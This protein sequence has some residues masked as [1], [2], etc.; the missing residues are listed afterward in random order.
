MAVPEELLKISVEEYLAFEE[1]S[2]VRH[3]Y[4]AGYVFA[5]ARA[6]DAHNVIAGNVF[7]R[8]RQHIRRS[9][10]RVYMVDMKVRVEAVDAFYYPDVMVTCEPF[11]AK[12]VFKSKPILLVEVL[13]PGTEVT[14]RREKLSAYFKL[15]SLMEYILI[16]QDKKRVEIYRRD[17]RG[18]IQMQV[19]EASEVRFESPPNGP[20]T[21]T[22][23]DIY[24]DVIFTQP[25]QPPEE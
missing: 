25:A 3:E 2:D 23:D 11:V 10:C 22:M 12:S 6:S 1:K 24:E 16:S 9:G 7:A 19:I 17:Q 20:L 13:S 15:E 8:A 21:L 18:K 5:M 14:D 4:V